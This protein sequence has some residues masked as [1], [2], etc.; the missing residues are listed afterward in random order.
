LHPVENVFPLE[1]RIRLIPLE[2]ALLVDGHWDASTK[3][4]TPELSDLRWYRL[5]PLPLISSSNSS[6][7]MIKKRDAAFCIC[8]ARTN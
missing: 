6:S 1:I 2:D 8:W 3:L 5:I 4:F 7:R